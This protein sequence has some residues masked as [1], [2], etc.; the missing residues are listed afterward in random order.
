MTTQ[1]RKLVIIGSGPAGLTA[2]VY[3]ARANLAP[4]ILEGKQP[5]GQLTG[6]SYVENWPGHKSILGTDLMMQMRDHAKHLGCTFMSH[7]VVKVDFSQRPFT[8]WTHK[9]QEIKA[10]SIIIATGA[11]PKKLGIPG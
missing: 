1:T 7:E 4:L 6:T 9:N 5:G 3:A 11:S 10:E 2:G 8:L